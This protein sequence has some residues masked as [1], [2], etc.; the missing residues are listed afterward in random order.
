MD[1]AFQNCTSLERVIIPSSV[2]SIGKYAFSGCVNLMHIDLSSVKTIGIDAFCSC[3][4]L[5]EVELCEG[6]E[7]IMDNAFQYCTSLERVILPSSVKTIGCDAFW[8]CVHLMHIELSSVKNIGSGAF[9]DCRLRNVE[10][11]E[12]LENIMESTFSHCEFLEQVTVPSSVKSIRSDAFSS[13]TNLRHVDL[14]HGLECIEYDAFT[15]CKNLERI[16]IPISVKSIDDGAFTSCPELDVINFSTG[17]EGVVVK[18]ER[19]NNWTYWNELMEYWEYGNWHGLY[20]FLVE[21]K[22]PKRLGELPKNW[23]DVI[24]DMI[25]RFPCINENKIDSYSSLLRERLDKYTELNDGLKEAAS[26]LELAIWKSR[27]TEQ[28]S[29]LKNISTMRSKARYDCGAP[30]IIPHVLSFLVPICEYE[31][32]LSQFETED[33]TED[34]IDYW[35]DENSFD[36]Y[37]DH[38]QYDGV[39]MEYDDDDRYHNDEDDMDYDSDDR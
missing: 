7:S 38:Y 39:D 29:G 3:K 31:D 36:S 37:D 14:S 15:E 8:G 27:I 13:C 4:K 22:I 1:K 17:V 34:E 11:C 10:L 12:G 23:R 26:L 35:T 21:H 32:N 20:S 16:C 6:A 28:C 5:R 24:H 9:C 18:L 19:G 25:R 33:V 30:V 2:K